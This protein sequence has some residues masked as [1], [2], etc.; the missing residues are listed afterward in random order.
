M[1]GR[2]SGAGRI[3]AAPMEGFLHLNPGFEAGDVRFEPP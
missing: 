1:R 3:F 2:V